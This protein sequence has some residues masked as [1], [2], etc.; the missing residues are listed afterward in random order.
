MRCWIRKTALF[1]KRVFAP[2][3]IAPLTLEETREVIKHRCSFYGIENPFPTETTEFIYLYTNGVPRDVLMICAESYDIMLAT[4]R[5]SVTV[6]LIEGLVQE[7][8]HEDE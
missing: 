4:K 8:L 1:N 7:R 5:A 2:S 3:L 6:D